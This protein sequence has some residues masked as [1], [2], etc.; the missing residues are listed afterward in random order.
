MRI[1]FAVCTLWLMSAIS[2]P[3]SLEA[4]TPPEPSGSAVVFP[5]STARHWTLP[6]GLTLIVQED[7]SAPVASVQVWCETGSIHEGKW[8]GAGLS[9]ILEHMLF[10]GTEGRAPNAIAQEVQALG[11]YINA[12]T[13]FDRTVYY[14]DL[15]SAGVSKAVDILADAMMNSTLPEEE[16]VKEQEVIRREFAM[17]EDDPG[18]V[19]SRLQLSTAFQAHPYRVPVIGYLDVYNQLTRDDVMAYYKARYVPNNL[20]FVV[21]GAVD[22]EALHKQLEEYFAKYPRRA[23]DP[24]YISKEPKQ[25]GRREEHREFPTKL[26]RLSLGWHI[27]ELTHPDVPALDLLSVVLGGGRSSRLYLKLRE[28]LGLVHS[29]NAWAYTPGDAGVFGITA[30]LDPERREAVERAVMEVLDAVRRDGVTDAELAKAQRQTL[31]SQLNGLTTAKGRAA[32]LGMNW[33]ATR[34]LNFTRDYLNAVQAV[35]PEDLQRVVARYFTDDNLTVTSL[36]PT[37]SLPKAESGAK[38]EAV[39]EIQKFTLSNGLR[40]LVRE[41]RRLPLVSAV[42]TFKA[43]V[44]TESEATSGLTRLAAQTLLKGTKQRSAAQIA[45]EIETLGGGIGA[46]G[47]QNSIGVKLSVMKPDLAKGLEILA[48]VVIHPTFPE[49][50]V[51]RERAVQLAA[52][53][54]EEDQP[55]AVAGALLRRTLFPGHPYGL[56]ASGTETSVKGL[57]REQLERFHEEYLVG[58]NGVLAVFGDVKAEEVRALVEQQFAALPKGKAALTEPPKAAAFTEKVEAVEPSEKQQAILMIG[59]RGGDIFAKDRY[60]L[61]L[62]DTASSDLGSRFFIRIREQ[63]GLAYFVGSRNMPGLTTGPFTFYLGTDP[64]KLEK[65]KTE[66]LDEIG[67][68]AREGLTAEELERAKAKLLG[69]MALRDQSSEAMA[70]VVALDE[71]YGLGYDHYRTVEQAVKAVTL[72]EVRAVAQRL[73]RDQPFAVA[74]VRPEAKAAGEDRKRP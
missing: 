65:V 70:H 29:V 1:P 8:L 24:V 66:F 19:S 67:K 58:A 61:D 25:L 10:K 15:P 17:G 32:D 56:K 33:M 16:Y 60:A 63:M 48:D 71:L 22:G 52:I 27:P 74:I 6:N 14:I 7:H 28:E 73:F 20:F 2:I 9:H 3:L 26:T 5:D 69:Q 53:K 46:E 42:A 62:I 38:E 41:D 54:A 51:E 4:K 39:A 64:A 40:L 44:L 68:L 35:K 36:N 49:A 47:G 31:S 34:N 37:G 43:G 21:T 18:R 11:G 13:T 55:T 45:E 30:T 59:Y 23:L 12:Y 57:T 72:E 50:A